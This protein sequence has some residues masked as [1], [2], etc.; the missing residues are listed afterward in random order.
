MTC[1]LK[2]RALVAMMSKPCDSPLHPDWI[3]AL[4]PTSLSS[5]I[6]VER[7]A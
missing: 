4:T 5:I 7:T 2:P 6:V 3:S 1:P